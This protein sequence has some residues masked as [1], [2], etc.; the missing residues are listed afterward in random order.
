VS[1]PR[2]PADVSQQT[3]QVLFEAPGIRVEDFRCTAHVEPEGPAEPNPTH[4]IALVRRG[5][6]GRRRRRETL[7]ADAGHVLFFNAAEPYHFA[8]PVPGGD[9]CTILAVDTFR[10]LELVS[11]HAPQDAEDSGAPFRLGHGLGTPRLVQLQYEL[12]ARA[13]RPADALGVEDATWEL[14]DEALRAAYSAHPERAD[15]EAPS[16]ASERRRRELVEAA[17]LALNKDLACSLRL[18]DLSRDLG[19]SP[20]H[21]SRIFRK[22][23]GLSLR[24]YVQRLR[25]QVAADRLA[26]GATDLTGL[27]LDLGFWDHSHFTNAFRREWGMPPSKFRARSGGS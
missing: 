9:D 3:R 11:R 27:A 26:R 16:T 25:A 5:V 8:H 1:V 6:F 13:K 24:R 19:C 12:L 17:K 21:L 14:A 15:R 10:A 7:V 20:F 18:G 2:R 4:S 22:T 23:V